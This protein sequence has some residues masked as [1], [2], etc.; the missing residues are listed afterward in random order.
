MKY[1]EINNMLSN[2]M[3]NTLSSV[4]IKNELKNDINSKITKERFET[5]SQGINFIIL[6]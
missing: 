2:P 5:L 1:Y 4:L 6:Y 3:R